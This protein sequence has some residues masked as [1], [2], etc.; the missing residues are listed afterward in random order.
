MTTTQNTCCGD[1]LVPTPK[2]I[3]RK[4]PHDETAVDED[5]REGHTAIDAAH[6][7]PEPDSKRSRSSRWPQDKPPEGD[8]V[9]PKGRRSR[10]TISSPQQKRNSNSTPRSSKFLEGS[11]NDRVS[12]KP[13]SPYLGE[14][15]AT[16]QYTAS[17]RAS[18]RASVD[19]NTYYDAGIEPGRSSGMYRFGKAL[20][21]A[22]N[23]SAW[24]GFNGIWK[25]KD[26]ASVDPG[27]ALMDERQEKA[28]KA[29]AELKRSGF[30]GTQGSSRLSTTGKLFQNIASPHAFT[31]AVSGLLFRISLKSNQVLG[32]DN[33]ALW[34]HC[35]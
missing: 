18:T 29:Y 23:P 22:F 27:K 32:C 16:E 17:Q 28:Q 2:S 19:T 26:K 25:E 15:K 30:R 24:R 34:L 3:S 33:P 35:T 7:A 10:R 31:S 8:R 6:I 13:P 1:D 9:A 4:R 21:N 12:D 20:V 14:E 5:V 11:M